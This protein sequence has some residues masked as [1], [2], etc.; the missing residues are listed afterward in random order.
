MEVVKMLE[1]KDIISITDLS[2]KEIEAIL[3]K[4]EE[5]QNVLQKGKPL[6]MMKG[7]ILATL[8][9]EPSTRT[10]LSF[11][12]AMQRLGGTTIDLG[13]IQVSSVV[14]GESLADTIRMTEKYSDVIVIRHPREGSARFAAEISE[15]PVINGG[16]GA[17]QHPTQT[18]LDLFSIRKFKE[19]IE[20]LDV[21]LIGD[22][23]HARTIKSLAYGLAIFGVN[24]TLV[25]PIGLEFEKEIVEELKEKFG[26]KIIQT[27]DIY[28]GIRNAD[29]LYA[30]RI[31]KERFVD[32]YEAEKMQKAYKITP[33]MLEQAKDNLVIMHA[34]PRVDEIDYRVDQTKF[35]K[36][37]EEAAFGVPV[38]M[39]IIGMVVQ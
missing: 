22:L 2:K 6:E 38:R 29:I 19:K 33:E 16:D 4:S 32:P 36:Y 37:F 11:S 13:E 26:I 8:F 31:Q 9:F 5:M 15:K 39:A 3:D 18:L 17:N 35:A 12:S 20:G 14:K 27:N 10:R 34:L 21:T 24:L 28:A 30:S 1:G 23:K 25:S 7:K